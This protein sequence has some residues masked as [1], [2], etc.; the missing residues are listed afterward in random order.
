MKVTFNH[1]FIT[2]NDING[3]WKLEGRKCSDVTKTAL[4]LTIEQTS[5]LLSS[6]VEYIEASEYHFEQ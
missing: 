2:L 1:C 3:K 6:L 5:H 4:K